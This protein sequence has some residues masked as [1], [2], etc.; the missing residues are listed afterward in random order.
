MMSEQSYRSADD[1]DWGTETELRSYRKICVTAFCALGLGLLSPLVFAY[2]L[3]YVLPV[4]GVFISVIALRRMAR[5]P[6]RLIGRRAAII[7]LAVSV[8]MGIGAP[9]RVLTH[10]WVVLGQ[11]QQFA[12]EWFTHLRD[13]NP[14]MALEL[15]RDIKKRRPQDDA[16]WQKYRNNSNDAE[17]LRK[18]VRDPLVATLLALGDSATVRHYETV[19]YTQYADS[20][21]VE[22]LYAVTYEENGR[23]KT[24]FV[25]VAM[26]RKFDAHKGVIPMQIFK[27]AGDDVPDA[28]QQAIR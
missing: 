16:L 6:G 9:T 3:M 25:R 13:G 24:F 12:D 21:G 5:E 23:R 22:E 27:V 8:L 10:R 17:A 1:A 28:L 4:G 11:A 14:H 19:D 2:P 18:Y 20:D 7:G 15:T 26:S